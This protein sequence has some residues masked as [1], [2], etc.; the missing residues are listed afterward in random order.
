MSAKPS[1]SPSSVRYEAHPSMFRMRPIATVFMLALALAGVLVA[2]TGT[3]FLPAS[4]SAQAAGMDAKIVQVVG[5]AVFAIAAL[6]L[7]IWWAATLTDHLK[8]TD[9][10][11]LWTRGV[12]N[13]QYT[14]IG[15]G[16]VRTVRVTQSLLQRLLHAGD[17]SIFTTGD[18]PELVVRGLP[19]PN[20]IRE[21]VKA[22]GSLG[23]G[24]A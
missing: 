23:Q 12:F 21:L 10:E 5:I 6:Q 1:P 2:V 24:E 3:G 18:I 4:L 22:R 9:D 15:M 8:I 19:N 16:S 14:E 11:V 13:K 17:I 7:L 20:R